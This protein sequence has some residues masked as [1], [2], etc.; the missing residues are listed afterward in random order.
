MTNEHHD[1][2]D[3]TARSGQ[4]EP[5]ET[6]RPRT[7][8]GEQPTREQSEWIAAS[9]AARARMELEHAERRRMLARLD[10]NPDPD[11]TTA[12]RPLATPPT[13]GGAS[14]WLS[15]PTNNLS[16]GEDD[17]ERTAIRPAAQRY[18][19]PPATSSPAPSPASDPRPAAAQPRPMGPYPV[20]VPVEQPAPEPTPDPAPV[21]K[22]A[23][24]RWSRFHSASAATEKPETPAT[25]GNPFLPAT[26][27]AAGEEGEEGDEL[28]PV[29]TSGPA[30]PTG[31]PAPADPVL[32]VP[33][34]FT[35]HPVRPGVTVQVV[36][37]HG[38]AGASTLA[39]LL[40]P[41]ALDCGVGLGG[42][43]DPS[44]PVVLV[45]RTHAKGLNLVRRVA[46]QWASGGLDQVRLLGVVLVDDAPLIS[47]MLHRDLRSAE[48][49]LPHSWRLNWSEHFRHT[50]DLPGEATDRRLR[51]TRKSLL[52]QAR[53]LAQA[54]VAS[55]TGSTISQKEG[56]A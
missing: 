1:R 42:L 31:A 36:G 8:S 25:S 55:T 30:R 21:V 35:I 2:T 10:G 16:H 27:S 33:D 41:A 40:G 49:A 51:R 56:T 32:Y 45:T 26:P 54:P 24:R 22:E 3:H 53:K 4:D 38:G 7:A 47:K 20:E 14:P 52:N 18:P 9:N 19:T 37:L 28:A 15:A 50:I 46:A 43:A 6:T 44:I 11:A 12:E 29:M 48:R 39:S 34:R 23:P 5:D 13:T 17:Q